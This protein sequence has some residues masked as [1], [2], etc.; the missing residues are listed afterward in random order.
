MGRESILIARAHVRHIHAQNPKKFVAFALA[1]FAQ[2]FEKRLRLVV[3]FRF[4]ATSNAARE[5][6]AENRQ[7]A[8]VRSQR[9]LQ[10][11]QLQLDGVLERMAEILHLDRIAERA[12]PIQLVNRVSVATSPKGVR[13]VLRVRPK[14]SAAP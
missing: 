14:R 8:H 12:P 9:V 13:N 2:R 3:V 10:E 5:R 4:A 6:P 7:D 11:D 1:H